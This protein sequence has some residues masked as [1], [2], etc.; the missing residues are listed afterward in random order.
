MIIIFATETAD[1]LTEIIITTTITTVITTTEAITI[2]TMA[3]MVKAMAVNITIAVEIIITTMVAI[4]TITTT[5]MYVIRKTAMP[6][7]CNWGR[8][9]TAI[10]RSVQKEH[11]QFKSKLR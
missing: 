9:R 5:E 7:S 8:F 6:P 4:A 1:H 3:I 2:T 11:F 10:K